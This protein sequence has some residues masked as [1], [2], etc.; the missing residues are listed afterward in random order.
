MC[1]KFDVD[2]RNPFPVR[3][4]THRQTHLHQ[5]K[6]TDSQTPLITPPH[7]STTPACD[8]CC[9]LLSEGKQSPE[10]TLKRSNFQ[11]ISAI[12][13]SFT[14]NF[15][16]PGKAIGPV[17]VCPCPENGFELNDFRLGLSFNLTQTKTREHALTFHRRSRWPASFFSHVLGW[18]PV[19]GPM[20]LKFDV[21]LDF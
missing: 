2:S 21:G 10:I 15:S 13:S 9:C 1:T 8:K 3:A 20:T 4:Q 14:N 5:D 18:D 17:C 6:V 19:V 7:V 16:G 11:V 12:F